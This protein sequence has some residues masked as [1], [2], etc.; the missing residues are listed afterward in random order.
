M[1]DSDPDADAHPD[2]VE[3]RTDQIKR[4][5]EVDAAAVDQGAPRTGNAASIRVSV[6]YHLD[7]GVESAG[8]E[9]AS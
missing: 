1:L 4:S 5:V 2:E 3:G 7:S 9:E 8:R 6:I